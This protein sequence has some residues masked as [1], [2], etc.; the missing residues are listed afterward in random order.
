[1][2]I[3]PLLYLE[4]FNEEDNHNQEVQE[5]IDKMNEVLPEYVGV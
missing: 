2:I 3:L 1:M 4:G 5:L